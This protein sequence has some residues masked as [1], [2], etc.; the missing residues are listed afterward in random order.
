MALKWYV[1]HTLTN[2]EERVKQEL[3]KQI[4]N[5]NLSKK[6]GQIL[7]PTEEV[8]EIKKNKK[9][10]KKRRYFPGYV[11]IEMEIDNET[12]WLVSNTTGVSSFL[13]GLKPTPLPED[14][15]KNIVNLVEAPPPLKPKPAIVFE[16]EE[17]VRIIEGPF[18]NFIGVIE[19]VN[20]EKGKLKVMVSIFGRSTPVELDFLQVE[21]L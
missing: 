5:L 4:A 16:K 10:T 9:V 11:F 2:Y 20:E 3:E 7:I 13:G 15:I 12:Y 14:E 17:S 19:D 1:I 18:A 6:L 8:V 21:K